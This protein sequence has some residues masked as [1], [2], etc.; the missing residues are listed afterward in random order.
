MPQTLNSSSVNK[1]ELSNKSHIGE[2]QMRCREEVFTNLIDNDMDEVQ[3]SF[4]KKMSQFYA[5]TYK[6]RSN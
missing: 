3:E 5:K 4:K 2:E 6:G 1:K